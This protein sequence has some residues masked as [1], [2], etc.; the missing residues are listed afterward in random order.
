MVCAFPASAR[1]TSPL[2][3][4]P[5][6][7]NGELQQP[8]EQWTDWYVSGIAFGDAANWVTN[9]TG[10]SWDVDDHWDM[11]QSDASLAAGAS[12]S[13]T[14]CQVADTNQVFHCTGTF[15]TPSEPFCAWWSGSATHYRGIQV[16]VT[17]PKPG[18]EVTSC[19]QPQNRCFTIPAVY[20]PVLRRYENHSCVGVSYNPADPAVSV[21]PG[22]NGDTFTPLR[23]LGLLTNNTV[24]VTNTTAHTVKPIFAAVQMVGWAQDGLSCSPT[25]GGYD[26]FDYP[27][28]WRTFA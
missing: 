28:G 5:G 2:V 20:N 19:Y 9:P 6:G 14:Y 17:A 16:T 26:T 13:Q 3:L 15:P 7:Q 18:L 12:A 4:G 27:F 10:C 24:T 11:I 22:S 25:L 21:I 1:A 23:G 8:V